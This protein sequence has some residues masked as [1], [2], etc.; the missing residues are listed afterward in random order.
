MKIKIFRSIFSSSIEEEVNKW[1]EGDKY[2]IERV[3]QSESNNSI[4]LTIFYTDSSWD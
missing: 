3:V 4:T 2:I 1:L